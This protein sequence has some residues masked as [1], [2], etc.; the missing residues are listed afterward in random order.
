MRLLLEFHEVW[1][2]EVTT[3]TAPA[4]ESKEDK[5]KEQAP[6]VVAQNGNSK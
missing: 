3:Y 1:G 5:K 2:E 4:P 6:Q